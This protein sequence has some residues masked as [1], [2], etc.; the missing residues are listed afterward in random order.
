L[1]AGKISEE[2]K[3]KCSIMFINVDVKIMAG[4]VFLICEND[5]MQEELV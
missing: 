4:K 2:A 3:A 1:T 5:V